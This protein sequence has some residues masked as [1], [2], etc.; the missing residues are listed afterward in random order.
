MHT[1][2]ADLGCGRMIYVIFIVILHF[3]IAR[4]AFTQN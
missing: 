4:Y 1:Q 3:L 2:V